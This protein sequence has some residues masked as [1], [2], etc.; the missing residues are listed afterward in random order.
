MN[1]YYDVKIHPQFRK[2][3]TLLPRL[4]SRVALSLESG[5][6]A[7]REQGTAA[8]ETKKQQG[9]AALSPRQR[10]C[11]CRTVT[12]RPGPTRSRAVRR[13]GGTESPGRLRRKHGDWEI[14]P[15]PAK[16]PFVSFH[17]L[18]RPFTSFRVGSDELCASQLWDADLPSRDRS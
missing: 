1:L 13:S 16:R 3:F 12:L 10:C 2:E 17:V 18:S 11:T 7:G 6:D 9:R 4:S 5:A 8:R 14:L 15:H